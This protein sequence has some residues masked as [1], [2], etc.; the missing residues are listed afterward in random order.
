MRLFEDKKQG[1]QDHRFNRNILVWIA[2]QNVGQAKLCLVTESQMV[3]NR[4][5]PFIVVLSLTC[6]KNLS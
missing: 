3:Q 5:M 4:C 1:I 2:L 6:E